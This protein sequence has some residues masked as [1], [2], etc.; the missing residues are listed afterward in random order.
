MFPSIPNIPIQ[1]IKDD[2]LSANNISLFIKREDLIHPEISGNKWR[3]LKYNVIEYFKKGHNCIVTFGG[4]FSN[5]ISATAAVGALLG[6]STIGIIRGDEVDNPT[7]K[8]AKQNGMKLCFVSREEYR[9]KEFGR[10]VQE[11]LCK[12]DKPFLIPEGGANGFGLLGCLEI[13]NNLEF[14]IVA[15]ACGTG[16]TIS[17]IISS[18]NSNQQAIGFPALKGAEFLIDEIQQNL[19][20]LNSNNSDWRL[21]LDYHFGGYAKYKPEL[22]EFINAFWVNHSIKLDPIYTGKAMFGLYDQIKSGIIRNKRVLFIH[23]GGLQGVKGFEE[24]Y[25]INLF[26]V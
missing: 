23:T 4:A 24:R 7:L 2:I 13:T 12:L 17:G 16:N 5:H 6:V 21:E 25:R 9:L 10:T 8:K 20:Y 19:N 18:L 15:C 1:E 3:K 26:E 14:D 11:L 22:V